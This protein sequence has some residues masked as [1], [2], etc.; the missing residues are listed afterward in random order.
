MDIGLVD[1]IETGVYIVQSGKF[2][3]VNPFFA[4]MTG[5]AQ[6]EL[7]GSDSLDLVHVDDRQKVR[8]KAIS[9]LKRRRGATP[10]E[11]RFIKKD[12]KVI[13]VLE[14][15]SS[16][17]YMGRKAA[18]GSFMDI[19]ERK[20][21]EQEILESRDLLN[22]MG[23]IAKIGGWE[24][25][26]INRIQTW[27]DEVYNIHELS[28]DHKPTVDEGIAFYAPEAT[29]IIS[30][31]VNQ[32][33][34]FGEPFNLELPFITAKGNNR[35]VHAVGKAN[36]EDGRVTKVRGIIQDITERVQLQEKLKLM[37]THD[38]LTGLPNRSLLLDRFTIAAALARRS[39]SK[40]A[41]MSLDLDKFKYVNDTLGHDAGDTV[42]KDVSARL[43]AVV[44]ASDTVA[45]VGGDEFVLIMIENGGRDDATEI[46]SRILD[47]F[48]EP[49]YI[50][51]NKVDISTS[52]G[53]A[54]Y[55]V[56]G[57]SL[58]ELLKK[59][60]AAMYYSKGHGRNQFKFWCDGD[61]HLG[62][63]YKSTFG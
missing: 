3:Y 33:I 20:M 50:N 54:L 5:Y 16:I 10:Y 47:S 25:N 43:T 28:H 55:P 4:N 26:V 57:D 42:L 36:L 12:G 30:A 49:L 9:N 24:F 52:I 45:R 6:D 27:T 21:M 59:S 48:R 18:L 29:A 17:K 7:I 11:Y 51:G 40:I 61:V 41:V 23:K 63:D 19:T 31:A 39:N 60:D 15:L 46:A 53:I 34:K 56:D 22:E 13:W 32:A 38:F 62:G 35:W 1:I 44:R 2:V 58:F 8:K 14:R 37:A